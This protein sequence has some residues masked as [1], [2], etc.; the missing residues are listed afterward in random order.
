[1]NFY[2]KPDLIKILIVDDHSIIRE[3]LQMI[4]ENDP[5]M[6]IIGEAANSADALEIIARERPAVVLLDID[7]NG[8]SGLDSIDKILALSENTKILILTG[9]GDT[10]IHQQAIQ[11]G[12]LGIVLKSEASRV[13]LKAI[14]A[15]M[16]GEVWL[17]RAMTAKALSNHRQ[18]KEN[19]DG[20]AKIIETL[21]PRE[22]ELIKLIAQGCSNKD[23]SN[24]LF[25]GEP[26]VRN[27]LT[28][29]YHKLSV[30]SR[31]ELAIY[32]SHHGLDK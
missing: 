31:L 18:Q 17:N 20:D 14:K 9:I 27:Y 25:I 22:L 23:I 10:D 26:T 16:N 7:L 24:R 32:A 13:L 28:V 19:L 15:L 30:S 21:M 3:G 12:A 1:M 8:E 5:A 6:Q 11:L 29:I 2:K 4:V